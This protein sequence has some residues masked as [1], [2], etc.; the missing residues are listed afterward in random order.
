[1][2]NSPYPVTYNGQTFNNLAEEISQ[3]YG[4]PYGFVM[5]AFDWD[6]GQLKGFKGPDEWATKFLKDLGTQVR[7]RKFDGVTSVDAIRMATSSGHGIGK[8]CLTSWLILWIMST[9]PFCKGIVTANT[10]AQLESKTWAELGKWHK[11]CVTREWFTLN[12]SKGSLKIYHNE[13]PDTWRVDAQT[14]K[15]ENSESF[16]GLHAAGS[17]PFFIF[18]EASAVPDVIWNVAEGGMTDGEPMWFVF[19]NPTRNAGRFRECFGRLAHRWLGRQ[20]DSRTVKITNKKQMEEWEKDY[21]EDSDF[22]RVRVKGEFPRAG[23]MQFIPSDLVEAARKR[24]VEPSAFD[25]IIFGVDVARFGDDQSVVVVRRGRDAANWPWKCFRGVD[26]M[27]LAAAI[28]DLAREYKPDAIFID[29]G[30]VGG[31]VID[32]LNML[33]LPV[34]EVQ[35]GGGSDREGAVVY[36]NKRAEIWGAMR[37][38]LKGGAIPDDPALAAE[39]TGVEYGFVQKSGRD[40]IQLEK[41]SDMK[42]RGMASPDLSDALA[43]TFAYPVME[44]GHKAV[45]PAAGSGEEGHQS[46]YNALGKDHVVKDTRSVTVVGGS[47]DRGRIR[48]PGW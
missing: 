3:F 28:V 31:G 33:K 32:R 24:E 39:L 34:V 20:V 5:F 18:D 15:E 46:Q 26:T 30:G 23:T 45:W 40:A 35:F 27:T 19:G 7:L 42:K 41:K 22:F 1:M 25:P 43:L 13:H 8:S 9:R 29:G 38:W 16:A 6:Y 10:S 2:A 14:C 12:S 36:A 21:G 17:T 47:L 44:S 37:E 11:L 48:N 4:D